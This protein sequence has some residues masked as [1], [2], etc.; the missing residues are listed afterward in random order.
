MAANLAVVAVERDEL[1]E[2]SDEVWPV[3][4]GRQEISRASESKER[5]LAAWREQYQQ[6]SLAQV[7]SLVCEG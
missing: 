7:C 3:G 2:W 1:R 6:M 4:P 5:D